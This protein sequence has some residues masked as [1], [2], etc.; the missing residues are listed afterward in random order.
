MLKS[1]HF[2]CAR[3]QDTVG[4]P[5]VGHL[6]EDSLEIYY[7]VVDQL[8]LVKYRLHSPQNY[9]MLQLPHRVH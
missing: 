4:S 6:K 1:I 8:R 9:P 2:C 5:S 7:G 3:Y